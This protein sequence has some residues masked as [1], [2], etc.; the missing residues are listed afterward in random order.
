VI[1][2]RL[3]AVEP[4]LAGALRRRY[5][6]EVSPVQHSQIARRCLPE[7]LTRSDIDF[8]WSKP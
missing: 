8:D 5:R 3:A 7:L 1:A 4:A 2:R 6:V